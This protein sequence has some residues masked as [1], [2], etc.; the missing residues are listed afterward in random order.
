M[1]ALLQKIKVKVSKVIRKE[2]RVLVNLITGKQ[3]KDESGGAGHSTTKKQE[4]S[5]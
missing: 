5:I 4:N 1:T 2:Q 3:T